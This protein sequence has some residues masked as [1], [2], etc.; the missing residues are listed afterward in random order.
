[1]QCIIRAIIVNIIYL[2]VIV[3]F[4]DQ[5]HLFITVGIMCGNSI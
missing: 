2:C 4:P 1:M 5:T 3:A